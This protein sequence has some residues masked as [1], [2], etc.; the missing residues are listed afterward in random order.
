MGRFNFSNMQNKKDTPADNSFIPVEFRDAVVEVD[1]KT[2]VPASVPPRKAPAAIPTKETPEKETFAAGGFIDETGNWNDG[3]S[4]VPQKTSDEEW[5]KSIAGQIVNS[6]A[7]K[8]YFYLSLI[9][10]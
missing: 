5:N 8:K 4:I 9:H 3:S 10:I 7:Y 1:A 6:N 2:Y